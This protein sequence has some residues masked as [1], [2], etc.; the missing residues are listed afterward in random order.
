MY[1]YRAVMVQVHDGDT[2]TFEIDLGF[3][4]FSRHAVRFA[5]INS[6]ELATQE[7]KV[8]ASWLSQWFSDNPGPY[9]LR[10]TKNKET[11]KYGRY[12]ATVT[13]IKTGRVANDDIVAAGN[14]VLYPTPKGK[15]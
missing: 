5:G 8:S 7:G 3:S 13:S 9:V 2:V 15:V 12:L 4:I 10:T 6:P 14:A 1:E 11:E